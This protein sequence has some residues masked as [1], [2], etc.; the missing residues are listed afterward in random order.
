MQRPQA[1]LPL[2]KDSVDFEILTIDDKK[3]ETNQAYPTCAGKK[4]LK[5]KPS[6]F[7]PMFPFRKGNT[8][9]EFG[10]C[11]KPNNFMIHVEKI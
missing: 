3:E 2:S 7:V 1:E 9:P 10:P 8:S 6:R 5:N 4:H 11:D